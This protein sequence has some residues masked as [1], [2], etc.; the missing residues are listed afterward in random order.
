VINGKT[1]YLIRPNKI[2]ELVE[3]ILILHDDD[4][5]RTKM[6][7]FGHQRVIDS[8]TWNKI[9]KDYIRLFEN[10]LGA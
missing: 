4:L 9:V 8:F 1:G 7:E 3:K 10:V 6:G 5:L 2:D